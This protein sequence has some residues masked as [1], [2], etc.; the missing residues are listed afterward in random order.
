[1]WKAELKD[2]EGVVC[3]KDSA[4]TLPNKDKDGA[5]VFLTNS[6]CRC[7]NCVKGETVLKGCVCCLELLHNLGK[8][9]VNIEGCSVNELNIHL[10][11]GAGQIFDIHVKG[12]EER[13]EHFIVGDPMLQLGTVLNLAKPG[14]IRYFFLTLMTSHNIPIEQLALSHASYQYLKRVVNSAIFSIGE[15]DKRCIIL[16]GLKFME[17]WNGVTSARKRRLAKEEVSVPVQMDEDHLQLYKK[18]INPSVLYKLHLE[19]E[20]FNTINE[21]RQVTTIFI[22]LDMP[23]VAKGPDDFVASAQ[24]AMNSVQRSMRRYEGILRQFHVDDKGAVMLC[25]FGLPPLA[26][27]NDAYWAMRAAVDVRHAFRNG[28]IDHFAIGI[29]TGTISIGGV[30]TEVR[31]EYALVNLLHRIFGS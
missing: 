2:S 8:Y 25:F 21:L 27:D 23:S 24:Y 30:G 28:N 6:A 11:I 18:Y 17:E 26:H 14:I 4:P 16:D 12:D 3:T 31:T 20:D 19:I 22:K 29:T 5:N 13:W 1:M 9:R 15:Y 10:G 7:A